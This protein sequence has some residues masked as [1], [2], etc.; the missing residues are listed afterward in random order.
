VALKYYIIYKPYEV[1]TRFTP[2]GNKACLADYFKVPSDVYPVGR[3][4]YDSEG[5]LILTNDKTLNQQLLL[6]KHAHERE[7][8]VQVD[9]AVT[10][11]AV[12]QLEAGVQINVDGQLYRTKRCR[13][14]MFTAEPLLP[15]RNPPI[16]FRKSIP[17]PW[18]KMVLQ[19]GKNRQVRRMTAAVGFPTLRLVRYRM[20]D[21]TIAGMQS[22]EMQELSREEIYSRLKLSR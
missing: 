6:P 16:R 4:D 22:G 17:A 12:Q 8:W 19:E 15:P 9:G 10:A 5:L 14:E 2:E 21:I 13:A 18:I 7:Y 3:L 1:L 11:E 20:E